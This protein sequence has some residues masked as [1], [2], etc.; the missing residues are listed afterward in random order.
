MKLFIWN[1]SSKWQQIL[2]KTF[3]TEIYLQI[4]QQ[5]LF[6]KCCIMYYKKTSYHTHSIFNATKCSNIMM[7]MKPGLHLLKLIW[8]SRRD[9]LGDE[10]WLWIIYSYVCTQSRLSIIITSFKSF[11]NQLIKGRPYHFHQKYQQLDI[12]PCSDDLCKSIYHQFPI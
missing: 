10:S 9:T 12:L 3:A 7:N 5:W 2:A 6:R 1:G 4:Y 8:N 11:S